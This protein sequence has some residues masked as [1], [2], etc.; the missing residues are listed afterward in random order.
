MR[1]S[2]GAAVL[3][4]VL[5]F[6]LVGCSSA[7]GRGS[8]PEPKSGITAP[9]VFYL[10]PHGDKTGS[11]AKVPFHVEAEDVGAVRTSVARD[12]RLT[13]DVRGSESVVRLKKGSR[14]DGDTVRVTCEV[15]GNYNNWSDLDRVYPVAAKGSRPGDTG[16]VRF[17]FTT[18]DGRTMTTRTRVVVGEPVVK[19]RALEVIDGVRPGA[20]VTVPLVVRNDGEVPVKGLALKIGSDYMDF[21]HLYANCRYPDP[22]HGRMVICRFPRL[23]IPP[24]GAV[25][26]SP[27]LRL[28]ASST[29]MHTSFSQEAWPLDLGPG[30]NTVT[31]TDG[32]LGDGPALKAEVTSARDT[33][34][35]FAE[36]IVSTDVRLDIDVDYEVFGVELHGSPGARRSLRLKVRNNGPG[37]PGYAMRL[38]FTPPPGGVLKEPMRAI[39]VDVYDP[40]CDSADGTYSCPVDALGPG[41]SQDFEFILRLD[42]PGEGSVTVAYNRPSTGRHDANPG[43]DAAAVTVLP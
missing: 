23:R 27:A 42:G 10:R 40:L 25:V 14:C 17:T 29:R 37:N 43:N 39:D 12:H 15:A 16:V 18:K 4:V 7:T 22:S 20:D 31:P 26:L 9:E 21:R 19:V 8:V 35:T 13:A 24:G 11:K 6:P 30:Q 41:E 36:G 34:G 2:T 38:V 3:G 32:E 5:L 28:R 33:D 1:R